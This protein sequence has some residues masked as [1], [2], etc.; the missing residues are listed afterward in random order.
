MTQK[1][2]LHD[3]LFSNKTGWHGGR[4]FKTS[5]V[6]LDYFQ[7][8]DE[9]LD[10]QPCTRSLIK[11]LTRTPCQDQFQTIMLCTVAVTQLDCGWLMVYEYME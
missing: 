8:N 3:W 7:N 9:N 1:L 6:K 4:A 5:G 10:L 11:I 2:R